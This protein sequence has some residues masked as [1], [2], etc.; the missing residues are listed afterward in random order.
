MRPLASDSHELARWAHDLELDSV[1]KSAREY[2]ESLLID[3]TGCALVGWRSDEVPGV[4]AAI[5]QL[6]SGSDCTV[7]GSAEPA[8]PLV[9]TFANAYLITALTACDVYVPSHCHVTPLVVPAALATAE[10]TDASGEALLRAVI[11]GLEVTSILLATMDYPEFRR[12]G[13]HSP[14]I[15]GPIGSAVAS[16]LLLGLDADELHTAMSLGF[17]QSAGTFAAWPTPTVKIHQARGA[18][19]GVLSAHLARQGFSAAADPLWAE[20]GGLFHAYAPAVAEPRN[21]DRWELESVSL[22]MWPGATPLQVLLTG[23]LSAPESL[24][25][26]DDV[27]AVEVRVSPAL[28]KA[29]H[30]LHHPAGV[31]ESLLSYHF[32]TAAAIVHRDVRPEHAVEATLRDDPRIVQLQERVQLVADPKLTG[33]TARIEIDT[34]NGVVRLAQDHALG[35]PALPAG[36]DRVMTKFR[37]YAA[38]RLNPDAAESLLAGLADLPAVSSIATLLG[39]SAPDGCF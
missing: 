12:R 29:H 1:P 21:D 38:P 7:L 33:A 3:A 16:G 5:K 6:G 2:A 14:G 32:A 20:D 30:N 10:L 31:F 15:V 8:S 34:A 26:I 24:P 9:A 23:L 35:S 39:R 28:W 11:A 22:R 4:L 37:Q 17:S 18:Y 13:W 19:A 36:R 25:A 27:R